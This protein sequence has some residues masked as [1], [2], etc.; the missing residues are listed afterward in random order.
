MILGAIELFMGIRDELRITNVG[1]GKLS[2]NICPIIESEEV[3]GLRAAD[4]FQ[5]WIEEGACV[6]CREL[7][8]YREE[9]GVLITRK[10]MIGRRLSQIIGI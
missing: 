8:G 10:L 5:G 6:V 1:F 9:C 7:G 3:V 4:G 2:T